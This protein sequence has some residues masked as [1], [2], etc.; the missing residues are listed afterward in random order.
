MSPQLESTALYN[1]CQPSSPHQAEAYIDLFEYLYRISFGMVYKQPDGEALAQDCAQDALVKI[2]QGIDDLVEPK[3]F[4]SWSRRIVHNR[5]IDELRKRKR[6]QP[7]IPEISYEEAPDLP[8]Q[9]LKMAAEKTVADQMSK[10]ALRLLL[11]HAPISERSRRVVIG[12]FL[13]DV[14]DETLAKYEAKLVQNE[15][16]PSHIQVTRSKNIYKLKK[17]PQLKHFLE[18]TVKK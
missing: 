7:L 6:L 17:W 2:H 8:P 16:L 18:E 10:D 9:F 3:A 5:T 12:R 14:D 4:L 13:D 11:E 1:R 15:V